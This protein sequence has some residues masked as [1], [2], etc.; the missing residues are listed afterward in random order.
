M[1]PYPS[2]PIV[3]PVHACSD[4]ISVDLGAV[5]GS[6]S[7]VVKAM[8]ISD[9]GIPVCAVEG[10]LYPTIGFKVILPTQSWTQRYLQV[11]CGGFCGNISLVAG[12]AKGCLP[13][14]A[15]AFVVASTDM[16]HQGIGAQFG[17]DP[18]KRVDFAY[19]A[20]HLTAVAAKKL[21][22]SFY[23][24]SQTYAYF[25]GCSDGGREA[26]VEAQRYP[27]DFNGILAGAPALNF[28]VQNGLFHA[29]Q[30][31]SN[32][33]AES[34]AILVARRLPV[35]HQAVV[36]ACDGLDGLHDGLIAN[37]LACHFDPGT[38]LC[39]RNPGKAANCFTA[40]EVAVV[41]K[42]YD[43]PRDMITGERLTMA[44]PL[45]GSELAWAGLFVPASAD[46]PIISEIVALEA[47]R[48][49]LFKDNYPADFSLAN[50]TFNRATFD[51]LR[52][53]H[54]LY[55][56]TNPD[57]SAFA[58]SGG[59]LIL[60]HGWADARVSP[61]NTMAYQE[62]VQSLM[63]KE[64]TEEFVRMY[65]FPGMS[66]CGGGEG[67][68]EID[69]LSPMLNWVERGLAPE[70]IIASQPAIA[71]ASNSTAPTGQPYPRLTG[72]SG[73]TGTASI[74]IQSRPVYPYPYVAA[75]D[76]HG[77]PSQAASYTRGRPLSFNMP[78]WAGADF[79]RPY[80]PR[81]R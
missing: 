43:G 31:W 6:G 30:A 21:I 48:N 75:Y 36:E 41:R 51:R 3:K 47:L 65:L 78:K 39:P 53:L 29:W 79:Y 4:L 11:G 44:G 32:R 57:L 56:A 49:L 17:S 52:S 8:E 40:A 20:V 10:V 64:R 37:P 27:T 59:K 35:L 9:H 73:V 24:R 61:I 50:M 23:D 81:E 7:R 14:Q 55:D 34:K 12:A 72:P 58:R 76:G 33:N 74:T 42:L 54:P 38:L 2:L 26:L 62:A 71:A 60:W 22:R 77:D 69:L 18:Q 45:F 16:G 66:H 28:Q 19:R 63:G 25:A 46:E 5:A 15:G 1:V 68:N 67:P 70:A 80:K 13:W